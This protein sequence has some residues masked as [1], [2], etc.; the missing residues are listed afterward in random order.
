MSNN[1]NQ[2]T[3]SFIELDKLINQ[4]YSSNQDEQTKK[5]SSLIT[6]KESKIKEQKLKFEPNSN[7]ARINLYEKK[8]NLNILEQKD[9]NKEKTDIINNITKNFKDA[10]KMNI[11]ENKKKKEIKIN[12][13]VTYKFNPN[14]DINMSDKALPHPKKEK[15]KTNPEEYGIL[16]A[17]KNIKKKDPDSYVP[18][19]LPFGLN[20]E[21]KNNKK[22]TKDEIYL[23]NNELNENNIFVIQF[24]KQIP[25]KSE[26]QEKQKMEENN[27][28][29][30]MY[31][32]NGYL[33]QPEFKNI[34][35]EIPKYSNLGKL[36][37]F[38][39]GKVKMEFGNVLFDVI[40]G[41]FVKFAQQASVVKNDNKQ[42][43]LLGKVNSKKLIVI[44]EID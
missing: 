7:V 24:P 34:F 33:I 40:P 36:K 10:E 41:S 25:I 6:P 5:F 23:N 31:D 1:I 17:I 14:E 3:F 15:K 11:K 13:E 39:S 4:N 16:N 9:K 38:K 12:K 35:K 27:N 44:P 43:F 21:E 30:P 22:T 32:D 37:I 42:T 28:D 2:N 26:N 29:E 19:L 8:E 20:K 18:I